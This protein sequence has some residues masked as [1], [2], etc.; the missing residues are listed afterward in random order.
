[1]AAG[2]ALRRVARSGTNPIGEPVAVLFRAGAYARAGG[3]QALDK[4]P[5]MLDVDLWT[6]M[7]RTAGDLFSLPQSLGAFRVSRAAMSTALAASQYRQ[8]REFFDDLARRAPEAVRRRDLL[9]GRVRA[10]ALGVARR[11]LY[12]WLWA[13]RRGG[14]SAGAPGPLGGGRR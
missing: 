8:A 5:Y 10:R 6:R 1:V 2:A 14:I 7:L 13:G 3:L 9:A 4:W 12:A 11:L